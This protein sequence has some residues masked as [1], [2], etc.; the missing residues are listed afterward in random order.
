MRFGK[1]ALVA[2]AATAG[3]LS[4]RDASAQAQPGFAV[5]RYEPS[6]QNNEW[7]AND[8]LDLRGKF[9]P[10]FGAQ[11][12]GQY[13]PLVAYRANGDVV[14]SPVRNVGTLHIGAAMNF[15]DR[16]RLGLSLPVVLFQDGHQTNLGTQT[17]ALPAND[18]AVGD[19]RVGLDFR[20]FGEHLSPVTMAI[21]AQ[22]WFPTGSQDKYTTDGNVRVSPHVTIAGDIGIFTYSARVGLMFGRP[23]R[24]FAATKLGQEFNFGAAAGLRVI[25]KNLVIGPEIFGSTVIISDPLTGNA[26]GFNDNAT[27][28]TA[29][30][31]LLGAH[32]TAGPVRFGAGGGFG[33]TRGLGS[34]ER[35][36]M[37]SLEIVP[38][39][40][41]D[42]DGDGIVDKD[43]ACPTTVGVRNDDPRK[44]G[45]P[46]DR[47]GDG[48][49]DAADACIDV[50]GVRSSDPK[51]NGC[52]AVRDDDKDGI[53]NDKD[54]CPTVAGAP[55]A[56]P[57]KNGCPPDRDGDGILDPVDACIDLAGV[58]NADAKKNGCPTDKDEDGIY[59]KDDACVD[60]KGVASAKPEFNGCPPDLDNDTIMNE[61]DACPR[62]PGKA[63]ADPKKNGCPTAYISQ[64]LIQIIDQVKFKT[65][66]AEILPGKDSEEILQAV[67]KI[68]KDHPELKKISVEGHTDNVGNAAFNRTLS[69]SR[70]AS[71]VKWLSA[72]GI[73]KGRLGSTGFGL[74]RPI[75]DNTTP[76][77]RQINRRVE[78]HI[79]EGVSS[80]T[81]TGGTTVTTP[82][83]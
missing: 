53:P 82:P 80:S 41:D 15:F 33:F 11:M 60:V 14:A 37:V 34:P 25:D 20:L 3:F 62:E 54:A 59:D 8:T 81:G 83:K 36:W 45:C 65:S 46:S 29:V 21:G 5:N 30:E 9:R 72:H 6:E 24:Y 67:L 75:G 43:D 52:P 42:T 22:V 71:V 57:A 17:I 16:V 4:S 13:R 63:N 35:S 64:G 74:D 31:G 38:P 10:S 2:F 73:E 50:P 12:E 76:E 55:N 68:L 32:Y 40:N 44:N 77:G 39:I 61:V 7:F 27:A 18:Q 1:R 66:S 51:M 48:I 28:Q 78:F 47:D 49:L 58:A 70:A 26:T 79:I 69:A 19:L 56:D 23:E